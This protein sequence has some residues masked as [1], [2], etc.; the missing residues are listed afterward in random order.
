MKIKPSANL[1]KST[2]LL[3]LSSLQAQDAL[4]C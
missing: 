4:L 3:L 1:V 2:G